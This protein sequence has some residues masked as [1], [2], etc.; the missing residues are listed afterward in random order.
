MLR[1]MAA[2][3]GGQR[4]TGVAE[5]CD[6]QG[7]AVGH[8]EGRDRLHQRPAVPHDQQQT[9]DKEQVI[10]AEEDVLNADLQVGRRPLRGAGGAAEGD[11]GRGRPDEMG[12]EPPV[13][14]VQAD[15][16][17]GD[18]ALE[19]GDGDRLAAQASPAAEG[20]AH[21]HRAGGHLL[22]I[23]RPEGALLGKDGG[24]AD[25]DFAPRRVLPQDGVG[26]GCGLAQLQEPGPDPRARVSRGRRRRPG[27]RPGRF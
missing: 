25:L 6:G 13:R 24:D 10:D 1:A 27:R 8:G 16:D 23:G 26:L 15:E 20:A 17:V 21:D 2:L 19:A 4:G 14:V 3:S 9:Q 7:D 11:G 5:G 12:F 22:A 18:R